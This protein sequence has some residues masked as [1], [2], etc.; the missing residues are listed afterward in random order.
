VC[1]DDRTSDEWFIPGWLDDVLADPGWSDDVRE[2]AGLGAGQPISGRVAD[3]Y[4]FA[5]YLLEFLDSR[6]RPGWTV[7]ATDVWGMP[8]LAGRSISHGT[9]G[10]HDACGAVQKLKA[11]RVE[12]RVCPPEPDSRSNRARRDDPH[13]LYL[14]R[15]RG[16]KKFGRGYEGRVKEHLGAGAVVVQVIRARHEDVAKAESRLRV[17][18]RAKFRSRRRGMLESFGTGTEVV[19]ASTRIDLTEWLDGEDVTHLFDRGG[20][21]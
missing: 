2:F 10:A 8:W 13:L 7:L 20:P 3:E 17:R 21:V 18:H 11:G 4:F 5:G 12:C 15:Y 1:R 19:P 14:V 16:L 9:W 6:S